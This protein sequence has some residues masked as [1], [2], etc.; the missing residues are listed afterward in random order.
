MS[1]PLPEAERRSSAW[2]SQPAVDLAVLDDKRL[3]DYRHPDEGQALIMIAAGFVALMVGL[4]FMHPSVGDLLTWLPSPIGRAVNEMLHPTRIGPFILFVLAVMI[5]IDSIGLFLKKYDLPYGAVEI[6]SVTFPQLGPVVE[7]LSRRFEMPETR[8]FATRNAPLGGTALGMWE[9]Y[10]IVFSTGLLGSLT[11]DEFKFLLGRQMG[12]V[13]LGHTRTAVIFG[14]TTPLSFAW[15]R[16]LRTM[17]FGNYQRA[18]ELSADRVGLLAT[19][20]L[21]PVLE[22]VTKFEIGMVRGAKIDLESLE[23]R[24]AE[25]QGGRE[26]WIARLRQLVASEPRYVF[27]L[28]EMT[29]WVGLPL[30]P[31]PSP[32]AAGAAAAT[33][34][35]APSPAVAVAAASAPAAESV[36]TGPAGNG[37]AAEAASSE[38][39]RTARL[40]VSPNPGAAESARLPTTPPT[41]P[42]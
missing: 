4:W 34:A 5:L 26:A 32:P 20:D 41:T 25:L 12:H 9:P 37:P 8:V 21:R 22:F 18:Q 19:R 33:P 16:K 42:A 13:K 6:N 40:P 36:P 35:A 14:G 27:R 11:V 39:V 1:D 29:R 23:P 17:V 38:A 2:V 28:L 7:E 3:T 24:A 31:A 30:P 10:L 15:L